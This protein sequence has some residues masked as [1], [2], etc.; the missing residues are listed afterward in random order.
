LL[1]PARRARTAELIDIAS[2]ARVTA[3]E[4]L[5]QAKL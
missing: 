2:E 3:L 4:A 5:Q 1:D